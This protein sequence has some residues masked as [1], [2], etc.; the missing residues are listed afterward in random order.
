MRRF[1]FKIFEIESCN[2]AWIIQYQAI[3]M[4]APGSS[5]G[6][7]QNSRPSQSQ[8]KRWCFTINNYDVTF[9][10]KGHLKN[11]GIKKAIFGFERGPRNNVPHI[12]GYLELPRSQRL[13][14]LRTNLFERAHWEPAFRNAKINYDYCAKDGEFQTVSYL[15]M[16]L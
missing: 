8:R 13:N 15:M 12:Q 9:D 3:N 5:S 14:W 10:Y 16:Y 2:S 7:S 6:G 1:W 11:L 4:S